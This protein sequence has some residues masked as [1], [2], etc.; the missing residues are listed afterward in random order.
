MSG[1]EGGA[2]FGRELLTE[3]GIKKSDLSEICRQHGIPFIGSDLLK[4]EF[5][6]K[7]QNTI[8]QAARTYTA[9]KSKRKRIIKKPAVTSSQ[10]DISI[11][12]VAKD[13]EVLVDVLI[14]I[15]R[16]FGFGHI[17]PTETLTDRQYSVLLEQLGLSMGM[18]KLSTAVPIETTENRNDFTIE[19]AKALQHHAESFKQDSERI[20]PLAPKELSTTIRL[21]MLAKDHQCT[22]SDIENLCRHFDIPVFAKGKNPWIEANKEEI[23]ISLIDS[24]KEIESLSFGND[25]IRISKIAKYFGVKSSEVSE[26]CISRNFLIRSGRFILHADA[27]IVLVYFWSKDKKF[28]GDFDIGTSSGAV[29]KEAS[30]EQIDYSNISLARQLITDYNFARVILKNVDFSNSVMT[31]LAFNGSILD[32]S[33]FSRSVISDSD[34]TAASLNSIDLK[35]AR[36]TNST[37]INAEIGEAQFCRSELVSC[38]FSGANLQGCDF[39]YARIVDSRFDSAIFRNTKWINGQIIQNYE[40]CIKYGTK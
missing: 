31:G 19:L 34:F 37:F 11:A 13:R 3:Y 36:I 15:A 4:K 23:L 32:G 7:E 21:K 10:L 40:E 27:S 8:G 14:D 6:T 28:E 5:S 25:E 30:D 22:V 1:I 33:I 12:D 16:K 29:D 39:S 18:E 20:E 17:S 26:Y 38:D 9:K 2:K 24:L 35:F